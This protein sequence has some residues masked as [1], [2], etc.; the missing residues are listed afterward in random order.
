MQVGKVERLEELIKVKDKKIGEVENLL[1]KTKGETK[2]SVVR[3]K[4]DESESSKYKSIK[5][6]ATF[7][8]EHE[9]KKKDAEI[10][11][12]KDTLK[13]SNLVHKD[14][15]ECASKFGRFELNNFYDGLEK[16]F[17]IL[18]GK[19]SEIY[20]NMVEEATDMRRCIMSLVDDID[21]LAKSLGKA[22]GLQKRAAGDGIQLSWQTLNKPFAV[23]KE[24][25]RMIVLQL[26]NEIKMCIGM[27][28]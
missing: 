1:H 11:K 22:A 7:M 3:K 21:A 8:Y 18:D 15:A 12:L 27:L 20:R 28:R 19:K 2:T 16:D 5:T 25:V 23:V 4:E 13:K 9:I 26:V 10:A 6:Q 17:N 24:E 14:K